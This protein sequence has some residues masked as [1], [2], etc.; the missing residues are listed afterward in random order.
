MQQL[1]RKNVDAR[2]RR[3]YDTSPAHLLIVA[4]TGRELGGTRPS[5]AAGFGVA[6]VGLGRG[7]ADSLRAVLDSRP[8]RVTLSVGFGGALTPGLATGDVVIGKHTAAIERPS[9]RIAFDEVYSEAVFDTLTEAGFRASYGDVLTVPE[10]LLS[11]GQ[12][13][14]HGLR[15]GSAVVD[16][17]SYWI[18]RESRRAGVPIVSVRVILD[19]MDRDLPEL[20]AAI[21]ADGGQNELRHA[22]RAM[23]RPASAGALLPLAV[24]ARK[25]AATI[26]SAVRAVIPT[27][28]KDARLRAVYR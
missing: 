6:K 5:R 19:E 20:V 23:L 28:T 13:R 15:T 25:A 1:T 18:A 11:A 21:M 8:P 22:F 24:R 17:E 14:K 10:P 3:T 9:D 26:G 27:L 4:P 2:L 16:M 12:K 7:A